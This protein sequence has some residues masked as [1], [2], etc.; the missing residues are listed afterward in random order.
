MPNIPNLPSN[1]RSPGINIA[2]VPANGGGSVG[3]QPTYIFGQ[4][5]TFSGCTTVAN[6][7][8]QVFQT[9]DV[10]TVTTPNSMLSNEYA[11]YRLNDPVGPVWL[12]PIAD[13]AAG[14][15]SS[16]AI[17]ITGTTAS[18]GTVN[19]YINN[20]PVQALTVSG[21]TSTMVAS[22]LVASINLT[23]MIPVSAAAVGGVV[24][25]TSLHKGITAGDLQ[26]SLNK[27]GTANG[28]FT[29]SGLA[30]TIG[31]LTAGTGE[32]DITTALANIANV[33][34]SFFVNPYNLS[35]AYTQTNT[36]FNDA[37]GRW[38]PTVQ[39]YGDSFNATRGTQ[40]LFGTAAAVAAY[41]L[42]VNAEHIT[43]IGIMDSQTPVYQWAAAYAGL[44]GS[45]VRSNPAA[46][47]VGQLYGVDGPSILNRLTRNT[48]NT[49]LYSGISTIKVKQDGSVWLTRAI[50]N[51]QT[52]TN[53]LNLEMDYKLA[54]ID[55]DLRT[56]L[57]TTFIDTG[58]ILVADGNPVTPGTNVTTPSLILA[59]VWGR[60]LGYCFDNIAQN[61]SQFQQ[62]SSV[63]ANIQTGVVTLVLPCQTAGELRRIQIIN[64]FS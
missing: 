16:V 32:P 44:A 10:Y 22:N 51:I 30:I 46:P 25:I 1:Y 34:G 41:G 7:P 17:T 29:P 50:Q 38:S 37:T 64:N 33:D 8:V 6:Y 4:F 2:N 56:D 45:V 48:E 57:Q 39:K 40:S 58:Y 13:N 47:I 52:N 3:A 42:T 63:S 60:Y 55:T 61:F 27:N 18:A 11:T 54:Y 24:T 5:L 21:D 19:L 23:T 26:V 62:N 59:H 31:A 20:T 15:Q 36:T 35:T 53:W 12:V 9:S 28:E 43:T 14:T 49:L